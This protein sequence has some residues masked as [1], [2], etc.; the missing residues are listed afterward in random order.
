MGATLGCPPGP[1][2]GEHLRHLGPVESRPDRQRGDAPDRQPE[3]RRTPHLRVR[4][5]STAGLKAPQ[6]PRLHPRLN[7]PNRP[8]RSIPK[9]PN[10]IGTRI[11]TGTTITTGA[12][13]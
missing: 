2:P 1:P 13:S 9:P 10:T 5:C 6:A 4:V 3:H 12:V 8:K 7:P 11:T